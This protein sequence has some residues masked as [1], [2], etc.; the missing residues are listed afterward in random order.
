MSQILFP[1]AQPSATGE[2]PQSNNGIEPFVARIAMLGALDVLVH[3]DCGPAE[4]ISPWASGIIR[5]NLCK[6]R[7]KVFVDE[8]DKVRTT[9]PIEPDR[10]G[11]RGGRRVPFLN[12]AEGVRTDRILPCRVY[13][14]P[15][16]S[17]PAYPF[18]EDLPTK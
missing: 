18:G 13:T 6:E 11:V 16:R 5:G 8:L 12:D 2:G 14:F 10:Q 17:L 1:V 7:M 4:A 9:A 15:S 3:A